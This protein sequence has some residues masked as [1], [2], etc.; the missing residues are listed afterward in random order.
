MKSVFQLAAGSVIGRQHRH[1]GKNNQDAYYS[2]QTEQITIAL[3][4]DG[5][6]SCPHSEIGARIGSRLLGETI[7]HLLTDHPDRHLTHPSFWEEL[8]AKALF[9]L[10]E[11][12]AAIGG[13]P[14]QVIQDGFLF[15]VVGAIVSTEGASLFSLGD[16]VI[17]I[18]GIVESL[19]PF[20]HNA[21]PYLAYE[22]IARDRGAKFHFPAS[23]DLPFQVHHPC[24]ISILQSILIGTDGVTDLIAAAE[25]SLPGQ[26]ERI[27]PLSQFWEADRYFTNPDQIRRR[28]ALM[29]REVTQPDW[30][31]RSLAKHPGLLPDDTTL[32]VI[33]RRRAP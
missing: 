17:V 33:R 2:L 27:G 13:D 30:E 20:P 1:L 31:T 25:I 7:A 10:G 8:Q 12:V 22:L 16:G 19:G 3:V 9:R 15:T 23:P 21:P 26:S 18:N 11:V 6:G 29:N 4:C 32:I 14:I 24:S 5:C 28:L